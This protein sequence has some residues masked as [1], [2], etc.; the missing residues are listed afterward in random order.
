MLQ[1]VVIWRLRRQITTRRDFLGACG[2]Q[3]PLRGRLEIVALN[4]TH[5]ATAA[6]LR[7]Y[8]RSWSGGGAK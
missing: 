5:R 2:P 4:D 1:Y 8:G 7:V 6:F 3:T